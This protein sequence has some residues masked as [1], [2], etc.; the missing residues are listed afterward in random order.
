M[1]ESGGQPP[2]GS[3]RVDRETKWGNPFKVGVHAATRSA[4]IEMYRRYLESAPDLMY[5]LR[6]LRGRDLA[7]WCTPLECHAHV[8]LELANR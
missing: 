5:D 6:D 1:R 4:V 7:C 3:V 8:L 2:A